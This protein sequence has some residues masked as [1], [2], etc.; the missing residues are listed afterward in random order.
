[1]RRR[2]VTVLLGALL[3]ALLSI[4]VLKAPVPYVVLGPGPTVDT[5]GER[6]GKEVIQVSGREVAPRRGSCG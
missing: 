1:M 3:T 2:G 4:G 6:D 5:L